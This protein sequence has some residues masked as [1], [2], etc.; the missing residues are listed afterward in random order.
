MCSEHFG[1]I[2]AFINYLYR[3]R[4]ETDNMDLDMDRED[5]EREIYRIDR[6]VP[7]FSIIPRCA[8]MMRQDMLTIIN[9]IASFI[10]V[11]ALLTISHAVLIITL[12]IRKQHTAN[13]ASS[14]LTNGS[15]SAA[16]NAMPHSHSI[17]V[18]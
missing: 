18:W 9:N 13:S 14:K 1:E 2:Y 10:T 15:V 5:R 7:L 3:I 4:V 8:K 16:S 12:H 6:S 17:L 11:S